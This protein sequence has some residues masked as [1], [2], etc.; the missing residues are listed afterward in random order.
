MKKFRSYLENLKFDPKLWHSLPAKW[1]F[2]IRLVA[3]LVI[4]VFILGVADMLSLP[5]R[6][7]PEVK[8]PLVVISTILPG[9]NPSDIE[10]LITKPLEDQ[11]IGMDQLD[12]ITSVSQ[13]NVSVITMQFLSTANRDKA[14]DDV[15]SQINSV[16]LPD[17]TQTPKVTAIDFE[18]QPIW[19]FALST[20][21][22]PASL[23]RFAKSLKDTIKT[24]PEVKEV[25]LGGYDTQEIT[26]LVNPQKA[27][28]YSLSP[29]FLSGALKR[30]SASYPSGSLDTSSSSFS[31]TIDPSITSVDD[32][33]NISLPSQGQIIHLGD[34]ATISERSPTKIIKSYIASPKEPPHQ[35]VTFS[36]FKTPN[37]NIDQ[38][39]TLVQKLVNDTIKKQGGK[40]TLTTQVNVGD[41]IKKQYTDLFS[42]FITT[43]GLV[44]IDLFIFLG[45]RQAAL[46]TFATPLTFLSGLIFMTLFGLTIN[47]VSLFAF[48]LALGTSIDDTI[49]IVS[50]MTS[51]YRTKKFTPGE[52][53]LL[54]WRDFIVPIWSTTVTTVW[55]Y[56]PLLI[57]TGIIGEFIKSIPIV[58]TATM[59]S[60]TFF[61]VMVTLPLLILV[62]KPRIPRRIV[63][64]AGVLV[65]ILINTLF[66]FLLPKNFLLPVILILFNILLY[67]LF[68]KRLTLIQNIQRQINQ[69]STFS[70]ISP[71]VRK[72]LAQGLI[73]TQRI[74]TV[75]QNT[76]LRILES[77]HGV[78]DTLIIV[79]SFALF[80]YLLVPLGLVKNEFF[81]KADQD[82]LYISLEMPPGTNADNVENHAL[83]LM[84]QLR[85][86]PFVTAVTAET[87]AQLPG[88]GTVANPS[89]SLITLDLIPKEKRPK[90][91][92]AIAQDLRDKYK[93]YLEGTI[94][95]AEVSGGPPAGADIQIKLLGDDLATL[96]TYA[97]KVVTY[98][99]NQKGVT[100]VTKSLKPGISKIAFVPDDTKLTSSGVTEDQIGLLLRSYASGFT[101]D[102]IRFLED[103]TEKKEVNFRMSPNVGSP[104][105]ITSLTI[106]TSNGPIPLLSLGSLVL[107]NN[108]TAVT[109]DGGK[110][111]ISVSAGVK[112]GFV[113]TDINKKLETYAGGTLGLP[114]GYSWKT[115]GV[116]EENAKSVRSIF[117]AMILSFIL[118]LITMVVQFHSYRQALLVLL[119]IPLAI[120]GVFI[121]FGI[122][123][124]P[125]SF[126]A[127]IGV[128]ALFGIVVTNAMFIVDKINRNRTVGMALKPAI[129]DAAESRLEPILL[130]SLTTI[131]GLIPIS[132]SNPLWRGLG[133]AIIAGL[134]F[135]GII[136][137]FYVPVTYYLFF[138]NE[139]KI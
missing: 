48:L 72:I 136:M 105:N 34:I 43:L 11:L 128:L 20:K 77:R 42:N 109:H 139:A 100:D 125:L 56:V 124:T 7:N 51:Y 132:I 41:M 76:I 44:F 67:N 80:A 90:S 46:A 102:K 17:N 25:N 45:L 95:V 70:N 104:E 50:A 40:F 138:K 10:S 111:T 129:A 3:L 115:G 22:D 123:A 54:V 26:V 8:I 14:R 127:L 106:G 88:F 74:Q 89:S 21:D 91:S 6:L 35:A 37:T 73:S 38:T 53:G 2:N 33:R 32:I 114:Q 119:L 113:T 28:Q 15:Q 16:T 65:F 86:V 1:I 62:L 117:E 9:A 81:P 57:T 126:P 131:L 93:N 18:N 75:Y 94:T 19:T 29:T 120:S 36:I 99:K 61:A 137:L 135:S 12:T 24:L 96:N 4:S 87:G 79:I 13:D 55:A 103:Q 52:T 98:L 58:V 39:A 63:I 133:G 118:I 122:T 23:M 97:D 47:F 71:K 68:R 101:L 59:Y 107:K 64:L 112:P 110:R 85:S 49:V 60:S 92:I 116:N 83:I 84:N 82:T 66:I 78:R 130:T 121:V 108:P 30:V 31:L 69:N 5:R 27:N 134:A